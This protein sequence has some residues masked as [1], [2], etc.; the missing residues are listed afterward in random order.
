[1]RQKTTT[2]Q[3]SPFSDWHRNQHDGINMV[4]IDVV[5]TCPAC[6]KPLFLADTIYNVNWSFI[7]KDEWHQRPYKFLADAA[8]IPYFEFFYTVDES[9]PFRDIIRFDVFRIV[10][11]SNKS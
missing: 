10:P 6:A 9:T 1:M 2:I 11:F 8:G 3:A 7:G 4:D 5:G